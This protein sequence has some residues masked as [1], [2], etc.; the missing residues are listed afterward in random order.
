MTQAYMSTTLNTQS[1]PNIS[2]QTLA[3]S[4]QSTLATQQVH[5]Q[6]TGSKNINTSTHVQVPVSSI[7]GKAPGGNRA[8]FQTQPPADQLLPDKW[9]EA[10]AGAV[11]PLPL[12]PSEERL[13]PSNVPDLATPQSEKQPVTLARSIINL[14]GKRKAAEPPQSP[15]PTKKK[16]VQP[17]TPP[18]L[19]NIPLV[20]VPPP[21]TAKPTITPGKDLR[22]RSPDVVILTA[23]TRAPEQAKEEEITPPQEQ[24]NDAP[25]ITAAPGEQIVTPI[26]TE[27]DS[28]ET[29]KSK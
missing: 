4:A 22:P 29:Q 21:V 14:L 17:T 19:P 13:P 12:G 2:A 8:A 25:V 18:I 24:L 15:V 28:P 11:G 26:V 3:Q 6:S 23:P 20:S 16:A 27:P 9:L 5:S 7:P 1:K 10:K